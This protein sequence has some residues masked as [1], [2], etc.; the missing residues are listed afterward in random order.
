MSESLRIVVVDDQALVRAGLRLISSPNPGSR[1]SLKQATANRR[2][3]SLQRT[4]RTW[5]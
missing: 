4:A 2:W 1:S 5:S 3:R